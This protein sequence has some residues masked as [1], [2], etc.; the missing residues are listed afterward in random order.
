MKLVILTEL[1]ALTVVLMAVV[2]R[3]RLCLIGISPTTRFT[4]GR[5]QALADWLINKGHVL[6]PRTEFPEFDFQYR[7]PH[8]SCFTSF[9]RRAEPWIDRYFGFPDL[10]PEDDAYVLAFKSAACQSIDKQA[11]LVVLLCDILGHHGDK[12]EGVIGVKAEIAGLCEAFAGLRIDETSVSYPRA[13]FVVNAVQALAVSVYTVIWIARRVT[14]RHLPEAQFRLAMHDLRDANS[15]RIN[16]RIANEI[17]RDPAKICVAHFRANNDPQGSEAPPEYGHVVIEDGRL[18]PADAWTA[19]CMVV[20]DI[21]RLFL[22]HGWVS[23]RLFWN[24]AKLPFTRVMYRAFLARTRIETFWG[25]DDFDEAHIMRSDE[26]RRVGLT[27][28]GILHGIPSTEI[29]APLWRYIDFDY[30]YMFG[31]DLYDRYFADRW[32][33]HMKVRFTGAYSMSPEMVDGLCTADRSGIVFFPSPCEDE[34]SVID[35]LFVVAKAFPDRPVYFKVKSS[36][37]S[38]GFFSSV[39]D[40]LAVEVRDNIHVTQQDAYELISKCGYAVG[41]ISTVIVE[42]IYYGV[43]T[44]VLDLKTPGQENYYRDFPGLCVDSGHEIVTRIRELESGEATYPW[45]NYSSLVDQSGPLV[46]D[47][48]RQDIGEDPSTPI[49]WRR[50]W[51]ADQNIDRQSG[52]SCSENRLVEHGG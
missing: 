13:R 30:Y 14:L 32:P 50:P 43:K 4:M 16:F 44:F 45:N 39:K 49:P 23:P 12:V 15:N 36:R 19:A 7:H 26:M 8:Y 28:L 9:F 52:T 47:I 2:G 20:G 38:E 5:L 25:R 37:W 18:S 35:A 51:I 1:N 3:R 22:Q 17:I 42:S 33:G 21:H 27:P 10:L 6:D 31:R 11:D 40:R 48:V 34:Q 46:F 41:T 29:L 24:V